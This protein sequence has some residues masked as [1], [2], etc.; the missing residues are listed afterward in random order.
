MYDPLPRERISDMMSY[1]GGS[2]VLALQLICFTVLTFSA[3]STYSQTVVTFDDLSETGSGS[4]L[5]T[6]YQGL[7]WSNFWCNNAILFTNVLAHLYYGAPSNGLSGNFYGMVSPSNVAYNAAGGSAEIDS[8]GTNF[9]FLSVYLTGMWNS[10]LNIQ[11]DGFNGAQE[12]YNTIVVA[13]ATNSTLFNF[14]YLDINRLYFDSYG[15]EPA[16][17]GI[18]ETHF[19]MDNFTFDFI[20]EPSTFLLTAIAGVSLVTFLRRRRT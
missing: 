1:G 10:N 4:F 2:E 19:V 7:T 9:N 18:N 16:F 15:G 12:I 11:V 3:V 14:N 6:S 8:P 17:D 13:S 20:P 5:P